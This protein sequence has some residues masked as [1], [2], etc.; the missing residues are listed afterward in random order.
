MDG[1]GGGLVAGPWSLLENVRKISLILSKLNFKNVSE[2]RRLW[3]KKLL[4]LPKY[5]VTYGRIFYLLGTNEASFCSG[6]SIP[7]P[8][9]SKID[10]NVWS[11]H[12]SVKTVDFQIALEIHDQVQTA[13]TPEIEA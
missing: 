4:A 10:C 12:D 6:V 8:G 11:Y 1:G 3:E 7:E 9:F 13:E 2:A 5:A